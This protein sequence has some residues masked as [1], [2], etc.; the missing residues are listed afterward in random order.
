MRSKHWN[1]ITFL[2][3]MVIDL[4]LTCLG[5]SPRLEISMARLEQA[6]IHLATLSECKERIRFYANKFS[7]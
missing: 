1:E 7:K 5:K 3:D 6:T 2:N 4:K